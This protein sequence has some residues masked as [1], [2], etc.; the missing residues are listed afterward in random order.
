MFCPKCGQE[1]VPQARF[2]TH[3]GAD[4]QSL[5]KQPESPPST[6]QEITPEVHEHQNDPPKPDAPA[7][8]IHEAQIPKAEPEVQETFSA[9]TEEPPNTS[10]GDPLAIAVGKNQAYYLPE[11][12]K[13]RSG[14]KSRFNWAAFLFGP[15]FCFYRRSSDLFKRFFLFSTVLVFVGYLV[16]AVGTVLFNL[17]AIV[18]G[19]I[20]LAI[21]G[22]WQLINM[23]RLGK[24]FNQHYYKRCAFGQ[25]ISDKCGTST[26][27]ACLFYLAVIAAVFVVS[28]GSSVAARVYYSSLLDPN[29]TDISDRSEPSQTPEGGNS[30]F[31]QSEPMVLPAV[32][33][34]QLDDFIGV[35]V[36]EYGNYVNILFTDETMQHAYVEVVTA[37]GDFMAELTLTDDGKASGVVMGDGTEP[38]YAIDLS[39]YPDYLEA[40]IYY[41]EYDFSDTVRLVPGG[42]GDEIDAPVQNGEDEYSDYNLYLYEG[43]YTEASESIEIILSVVPNGTSF[44]CELFWN[45]GKLLELGTVRPGVPTLL[46]EGTTITIDLEPSGNIHVLLEGEDLWED[47]YSFYMTQY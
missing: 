7:Q 17:T 41:S 23:I 13:I 43:F 21:A 11:F 12:Q 37:A 18:A 29:I 6:S 36:D 5:L 4:I 26:K 46:S 42:Y 44:A 15:A 3:C 10:D 25:P 40:T 14:E 20:I 9:K 34:G 38:E 45:Y 28:I 27:A 30:I 19:G 24:Q 35:W 1:L 22:I 39:K 33:T 2:C 8:E 31:D 47:S 16:T 32:K